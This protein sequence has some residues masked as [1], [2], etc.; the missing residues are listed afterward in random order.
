[1]AVDTPAAAVAV[2]TPAAVAVTAAAVDMAADTVVDL[3]A[4]V[5][6]EVRNSK[7]VRAN[8]NPNTAYSRSEEFQILN[9]GVYYNSVK[10]DEDKSNIE[11]SVFFYSY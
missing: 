9:P 5:V 7:V 8:K 3:G 1:M 6:M 2:D 11:F 10:N 4:V